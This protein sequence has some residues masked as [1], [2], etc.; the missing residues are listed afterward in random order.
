M[1]I[2][3]SNGQNAKTK[4]ILKTAIAKRHIICRIK[5]RNIKDLSELYKTEDNEETSLKR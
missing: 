2:Y 5:M 1:R 4:K 3:H